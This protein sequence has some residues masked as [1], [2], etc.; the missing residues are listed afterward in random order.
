MKTQIL[1]AAIA[2]SFILPI[3]FGQM[4]G[5]GYSQPQP[6]APQSSTGGQQKRATTTTT[7][8]VMPQGGKGYVDEQLANSKR[9]KLHVSMN[10]KDRAL[11]P[12]KIHEGGKYTTPVDMIGVD[13]KI[14]E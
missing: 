14:Y 7:K 2:T 12:I 4:P 10:G 11:T 8:K 1:I 6:Q 9:K 3:A 13:G 5:G